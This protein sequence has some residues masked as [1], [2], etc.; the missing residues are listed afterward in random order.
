MLSTEGAVLHDPEADD[1][2]FSSLRELVDRS[3]VEVHEVDAELNDPQ[4]ALAMAE[5]LHELVTG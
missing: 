1:A 2:L 3:T 4:F 5:R